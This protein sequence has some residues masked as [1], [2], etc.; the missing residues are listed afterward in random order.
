MK[1]SFTLGAIAG[2][3]AIAL[4]IPVL[5]Q[6]SSAASLTPTSSAMPTMMK[7]WTVQDLITRDQKFL[8]NIDA[9]VTLE[10]SAVQIHETALTAA[11]AIT[12]PAAQKTA[13][14][15]ANSDEKATMDAAITANAD[16]KSAMMPFGGRGPGMGGHGTMGMG[17]GF[18]SAALATKLGMTETDLK[19]ALAG[20]QTIQQIA[21]SKGI[22][23]PVRPAFKGEMKHHGFGATTPTTNTTSSVTAQ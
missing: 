10:K 15:K 5:A 16:L 7:Q 20:G 21:E 14:Q 6:I 23:L 8:A 17:Q 1:K 4:A 9:A 18:G 11:A 22:T 12:D 3:S 13:I 19:A 2:M